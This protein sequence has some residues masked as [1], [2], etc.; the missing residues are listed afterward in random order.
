MKTKHIIFISLASVILLA[1]VFFLVRGMNANRS[2]KSEVKEFLTAFSQ[3]V[4]KG[5]IDS[6]RVYFDTDG[7]SPGLEKLITI[8]AH[9]TSANGVAKPLANI[10]L[11]VDDSEIKFINP[12]LTETNI[13]VK[14]VNDTLPSKHSTLILR[15]QKNDAHQL[16][17]VQAD[18]KM[19]LIDLIAYE[20]Y[21]RSKMY[22]DSEIYAAVTLKAFITA[23]QL[24]TRYDSVIWFAHVNA[25]TYFYV[26]KGVWDIY[27]PGGILRDSTKTY[28]MGLV[29]P[30]LKEIIPADFDLVHNISGTFNDLVEVEKEHKKGFYNLTGKVVVPVNYDHIFPINDD[31]NLAVLQTAADFYYL[32]KDLTIS[33]RVDLKIVDILPRLKQTNSFTMDNSDTE[34]IT[35]HNSRIA[36]GTVYITPSYL[37]DLNLLPA[38]KFFKNPLRKNIEYEDVSTNY[39]VKTAEHTTG[40]DNWFE[41]AFYN[42]RDYFLGGRAEFYDKKNLIIVDKRSNKILTA[43]FYT[44]HGNEEGGS[45]SKTICDFNSIKAINDSLFE[46]RSGSIL[47][48]QL[49]DSTKSVVGGPYYYYLAVKGNKLVELKNRR[50]FGFTKYV[51]MD[52]AYLQA[53][54]ELAEVK[55]PIDHVTD[56]M[57]LY[58]KNEIYADYRYHFK[59]KRWRDI[60]SDLTDDNIAF[61]NRV[62]PPNANVDDSLTV[63]DKYNINFIDQKLKGV[64]PNVIAAK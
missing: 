7:K 43:D 56:D 57:L 46:V 3:Q 27:S 42:I 2:E 33:E 19:F 39:I 23:T 36:H 63:I 55:R 38:V 45:T 5:N 44:D 24:K 29:G 20:N 13:P 47:A 40:N 61:G 58:M 28:K 54:Y 15:L 4:G 25:K 59:D 18:A 26:I 32:K 41:S 37:V 52:D 6:L 21:I 34:I 53:C 14:F 51:K 10:S 48:I 35:E 64:R 16:K 50:D 1:S 62:Q 11:N 30:D 31:A 49:Y 22:T 60:F 9:L 17:I 8:L 12:Q